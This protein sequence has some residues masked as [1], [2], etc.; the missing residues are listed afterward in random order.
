[1]SAN[2]RLAVRALVL[3]VG[4]L[5]TSCYDPVHQDA[6]AQLGDEDPKVPK[7][8]LHRPGQ[9]CTTCHG[10]NGPADL[11]LSV[12]GT[13][14]TVRGSS[15]PL[16]DV[17]V[18]V[19]DSTGASRTANSNAAGNFYL[20]KNDWAPAFPLHV[21]LDSNGDHRVMISRIGRDGGCAT[22]H[23]GQGDSMSMPGVFARNR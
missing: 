12:A 21:T 16:A 18:T 4:T 10:G 13:V 22:C 14:F 19:T 1:M 2:M 8:P 7:G 15:D 6:V 17:V 9:P 11:E 3:A 20:A 5:G 23:H